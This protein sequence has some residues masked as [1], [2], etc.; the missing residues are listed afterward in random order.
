[1]CRGKALRTSCGGP[2]RAIFRLAV[3]KTDIQEKDAIAFIHQTFDVQLD[4]AIK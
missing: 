2:H 4:Y 1:M 3:W